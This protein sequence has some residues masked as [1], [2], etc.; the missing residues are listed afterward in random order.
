MMEIQ[1]KIAKAKALM[2]KLDLLP[3]SGLRKIDGRMRQGHMW[4][5]AS[6]QEVNGLPFYA[7]PPLKSYYVP[8][9][10]LPLLTRYMDG[11]RDRLDVP[12]KIKRDV[13]RLAGLLSEL[14]LLSSKELIEQAN[15][16]PKWFWELVAS[17]AEWFVVLPPAKTT[18][19]PKACLELFLAAVEAWRTDVAARK[20]RRRQVLA[21][22][23]KVLGPRGPR[24]L[25]ESAQVTTRNPLVNV[26]PQ[27]LRSI[28]IQLDLPQT[29]LADA[30]GL[31]RVTYTSIENGR[32]QLRLAELKIVETVFRRKW[33]SRR[34]GPYPKIHKS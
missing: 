33:N 10:T 18:W 24:L 28:R 19:M 21:S 4:S 20:E 16:R 29:A 27:T 6:C 17:K 34:F 22:P 14:E 3:I 25:P 30:L 1:K 8:R 11:E 9:A 15:V 26:D 31:A 23:K 2:A 12:L 5:L 13:E 7:L 32:R